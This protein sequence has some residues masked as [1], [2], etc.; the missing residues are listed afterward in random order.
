MVASYC[1]EL[2]VSRSATPNPTRIQAPTDVDSVKY[3]RLIK[4]QVQG[5][6]KRKRNPHAHL[7]CYPKSPLELGED[8]VAFI[9]GST[10]P[11]A[12]LL[13]LF[14]KV[15]EYTDL[16]AKR[17][18]HKSLRENGDA[19]GGS[20]SELA[21]RSSAAMMHQLVAHVTQAVGMLQQQL[22]PPRECDVDGARIRFNAIPPRRPVAR[23]GTATAGD[24]ARTTVALD[25]R[26]RGA[27]EADASDGEAAG[28]GERADRDLVAEADSAPAR[29]AVV[30]PGILRLGAKAPGETG[31]VKNPYDEFLARS[32]ASHRASAAAKGAA[33]ASAAKV[34]A[35]RK[36]AD[37]AGESVGEPSDEEAGVNAG[38]GAEEL[39]GTAP[40]LPGAGASWPVAYKDFLIYD[41]TEAKRF[42][43]H[44]SKAKFGAVIDKDCAYQAS[45]RAKA[46]ADTISRIDGLYQTRDGAT[47]PTRKKAKR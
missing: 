23:P 33:K 21:E 3:A 11:V 24:R 4:S 43:Y 36:V 17:S 9:Y 16:I 8:R 14:Q 46:W 32:Q 20:R 28:E 42:R 39:E 29:A 15:A 25:D 34:A 26:E 19:R 18:N 31:R 40:K 12:T 5:K 2:A 45:G 44:T 47:A 30:P 6:D 10:Q 41:R 35:K 38:A 37:D 7:P 1:L 22:Q 27:G 13:P